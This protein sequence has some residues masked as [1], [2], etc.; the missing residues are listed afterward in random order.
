MIGNF[1]RD[2]MVIDDTMFTIDECI[3][4]SLLY[5]YKDNEVPNYVAAS[6]TRNDDGSWKDVYGV[7]WV[8]DVPQG[9]TPADPNYTGPWP[10]VE[11]TEEPSETPEE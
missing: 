7:L 2:V 11:E 5:L 10:I 9:P 3:H 4:P 8:N 6:W 1:C